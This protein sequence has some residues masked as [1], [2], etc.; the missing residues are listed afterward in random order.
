MLIM[1]AESGC[2][3]EFL[4][5]KMTMD[6][7]IGRLLL[8]ADEWGI[9]EIRVLKPEETQIKS[10]ESSPLLERAAQELR[11]YFAGTR[12]TFDLPLLSS[13][14]AF[15]QS[16]WRALESI[17]FGETKSYG[18]LAAQLG[19]PKAARAVGRACARN[20]L[21]IVVPCHRVIASSGALTGF[22]A[23]IEAKRLLLR[24]EGHER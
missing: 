23:G 10:G 18:Q 5:R 8:A 11:E 13:G 21:L 4:T 24:L 12:R 9:C 15:E 14:T 17:P 3:K 20:P 2:V 16:V 1:D 6:S 7:P 19:M 22:A